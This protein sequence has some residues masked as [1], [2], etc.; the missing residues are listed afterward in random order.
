MLRAAVASGSEVGIKAKAIM[1]SGGLVSDDIIVS[2]IKER[3]S[4]EDCKNGFILDGFPRTSAQAAALDVMLA[5][6]NKSLDAVIEIKVDDEALVERISGRFTC[7]KCGEGY[8]KIFKKPEKEGVCDSCGGDQF[9]QRSDDNAET[10][11]T[12]L[13]AY[14]AQTAPLIPYYKE[15]G[16][17]YTVDGMLSIDEVTKNI[18]DVLKRLTR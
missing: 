11:A 9:S 1:E 6:L 12:R 4:R 5:D 16:S 3:I 8:N 10:V 2:M 7:V 14:H 13:K 18:N 17:L 15:K